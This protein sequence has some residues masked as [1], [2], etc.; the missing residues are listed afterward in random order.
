M[1]EN[2]DERGV[3]ELAGMVAKLE[4]EV[5]DLTLRL[6]NEERRADLAVEFAKMMYFGNDDLTL[7]KTSL[8]VSGHANE[9]G[10]NHSHK[11]DI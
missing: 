7:S 4:A 8:K 6:H 5:R 11:E 2:L 9:G 1:T 10:I 3:L